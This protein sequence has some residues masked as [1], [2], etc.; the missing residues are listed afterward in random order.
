MNSCYLKNLLRLCDF[1][2]EDILFLIKYA[3]KLK[4][5]KKI[6]KEKKLLKNKNIV[7]LFEKESTRTR[8]S[9]EIAAFNQGA[10][11]TYL[12]PGNTH[13][14]Y[15]ES[16]EDTAITLGKIYDGIIYRGHQHTNIEKLAQYAK[17]P[18]WN[19]LTESFHPTQILSDLLTIQEI[20]INTPLKKIKIAY[21]GDARN[22]IANSL[23][24]ASQ[25]L[26]FNLTLVSPKKYFQKEEF[27]KRYNVNNSYPKNILYT[28][29]IEKGVKKV[30]LIYTDVWISMGEKIELQ[31][32]K[33]E[34]LKNYQVN[35]KVLQLTENP[36]IKV[37]H[38]LPALH[39]Q[40]TKFGKKIIKKFNLKNGIEISHD[41]FESN[42]K[43][44]FQ[45]SEN[46][47]HIAKALL[48]NCLINNFNKKIK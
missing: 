41:V 2:K 19:G 34:L 13:L 38:C 24:E 45:Q 43:I 32:K 36:L 3:K 37:F 28:E 20:F 9:F 5:K 10:K 31:E 11:T 44:I 6:N 22:N 25:I 30:D 16:I 21:I 47:I 33:I 39:D 26:N 17:I 1:C 35:Q 15:K 29:D 40:K 27:F 46:R 48:I 23:V 18:V 12:G 42:K 4:F 8:C 7:L 14:G